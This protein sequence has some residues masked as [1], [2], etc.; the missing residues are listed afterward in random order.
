MSGNKDNGTCR[1]LPDRA[2]WFVCSECGFEILPVFTQGTGWFLHCPNC[3]RKIENLDELGKPTIADASTL[4]AQL[5]ASM[6]G[7]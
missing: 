4:K 1:A 3:G 5:L 2:P 7:L 6:V